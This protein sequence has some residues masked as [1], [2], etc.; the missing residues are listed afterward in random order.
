VNHGRPGLQD[1]SCRAPPCRL[2]F[3][4]GPGGMWRGR[5]LATGFPAPR[6]ALGRVRRPLGILPRTVLDPGGPLLESLRGRLGA[7]PGSMPL[8]SAGADH[9]LGFGCE[10]PSSGLFTAPCWPW[11]PPPAGCFCCPGNFT[12][13]CA[14]LRFLPSS[15]RC[16]FDLPFRIPPPFVAT[17]DAGPGWKRVPEQGRST[18]GPS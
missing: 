5:G 6:R 17:T 8:A 10:W 18:G 11:P 16:C 1:P 7:G 13:A 3:W 15:G 2:A 12:A 9:L 14:R 4:T